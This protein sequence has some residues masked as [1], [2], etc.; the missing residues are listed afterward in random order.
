M[1]RLCV[2]VLSLAAL[3]YTVPVNAQDITVGGQLRPRFE[4]RDPYSAP[5][6]LEHDVFTSMRARAHVRAD[7][8][9]NVSVMLQFQDVRFWG[10]FWGGETSTLADFSAD[11]LDIHQAYVDVSSGE[12]P[13]TYAARV[14]RQEIA[15]GGH[16]LIGTVNWTQQ[17]RS[18]DALRLSADGST[19]RLDV[20]GALL[21]DATAAANDDDAYLVGAYAQLRDAGP[22]TLD[23]YGLF[24]T[25]FDR[26]GAGDPDIE[27]GTFGA[28]WWGQ[29]G[30]VRFRAEA[31]YQTGDRAGLD[32]SAFMFGGR[33][34][35]TLADG[36][37]SITLW[38]DY[39]SGDDDATD[40]DTKVFD[41]LFATNHKFYGFADLFLNIPVHTGGRGLQD[42][43]VKSSYRPD[44]RVNL[45]LDVHSFHAAKSN[46]L[47]TGH[48]G[49][50][51]D[52]T[53]TYT[54]S[55][56]LRVT[57]GLSQVFQ[58]DG[59]ADIGRL[60]ENMMDVGF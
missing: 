7:L 44:P 19:V 59:F 13:I 58:A 54:H 43:A 30:N 46:G 10:G 34:G 22:G 15:F 57:S 52:L 20:I 36:A 23:V 3:I 24:N 50:E 49:E 39:L 32:V 6:G 45:A 2:L 35:T 38:Y 60:T 14:G 9:K 51:V 4:F 11:N 37:G 12:G 21:Q 18:F 1:K 17:A 16:R 41:T 25:R 42:I 26:S 31:S 53:L 28:R 8:E 29:S 27:Q 40:T 5:A 48:F 56:N 33:V 47:S 55:R